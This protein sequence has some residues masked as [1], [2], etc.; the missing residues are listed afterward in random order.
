VLG[1]SASLSVP[2]G[3][4]KRALVTIEWSPVEPQLEKKYYVAGL[5]EIK[6]QVVQGGHESFQ[7]VKVTHQP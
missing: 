3:T 1:R 6:E 2:A 5:G 7:L 4:F